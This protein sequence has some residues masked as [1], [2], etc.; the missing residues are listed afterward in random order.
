[1]RF[2]CLSKETR[3]VRMALK[4]KQ[5][6]FCTSKFFDKNLVKILTNIKLCS[7]LCTYI[8]KYCVYLC[9][10]VAKLLSAVMISY[11]T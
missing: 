2:C 10:S 6:I 5:Y 8:G 7:N 4:G 11:L 9:S 1:M 3:I